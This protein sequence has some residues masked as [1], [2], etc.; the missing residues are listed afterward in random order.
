MKTAVI[1]GVRTFTALAAFLCLRAGHADVLVYE[2]F[3][4]ADYGN[5]AADGNVQAN[6]PFSAGHTI[7]FAATGWNGMNGTQV[8]VFGENYG[9]ALPQAM[10][11]AGFAATGGSVGL[12]P[13]SNSSEMR[14]MNHALASDALKTNSATLYFRMLLNLDSVAAGKLSASSAPSSAAGRYF[15]CGF[16]Q[17][18]GGNYYLLTNKKSALAFVVWKNADGQCVLSLA[19]T[20][21]SDAT[22]AFY[23]LVAGIALG[24]TYVC[25]AEVQVGAGADGKE[26]VRAGAVKADDFAGAAPWAAIGG[27]SDFVEVQ[28]MTDSSYPTV[29]AV[30]GPYGTNNGYFRAD[31]IVVGTEKGDVLPVSGVF[32]VAPSGAPTVGTD[33]FSTGWILVADQGVTADAAIVWSADE[34]FSTATTNSLGTGLSAGTRTASLSGLEPDTAYW[35]KIVADSGT[36]VAETPVLSFT[37]PGAPV[38]G[39]A[40]VALDGEAATFSVDLAEAAMVN[41]LATSVSVLY[42]TDGE[43]WTELRLGSASAAETFSGTATNLGFGVSYRWFARAA[44]TTEGGRVLSS[45][46]PEGSFTTL[47]NGDMYVDA[48]AT[49][50]APPYSTPETAAAT[51]AAA[52]A[53]ADDGA[54][55]HV[56]PGVYPISSPVAVSKAVRILGAGPD[57]SRTVVSNTVDASYYRQNQRVFRIDNAGALVANLTMQNGKCYSDGGDFYIAPAGG[58]VSN[59]VVEAGYTRDNGRAAGGWLDAGVVTHTVFRRNWSGSASVNWQGNRPGL[60]QLNGQ[61]RAE[62]CLFVG[63]DQFRAV[64]LIGMAGSSVMRNCTIVDTGLSVT[65]AYCESWSAL[66]IGQGAT[67]QNVVVA[68][69]TNTVDGAACRPTG[70]RENF[71]NGALD[72]PVEG[73]AFPANTVVGTAGVFFADGAGGDYVPKAGGPLV[74][75]GADGDEGA[76][77]DLAG[78]RRKVGRRVDIGCYECQKGGHFLVVVK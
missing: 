36:A 75:A 65:N 62:N 22:A 1:P 15:G 72:S 57:P 28:L 6:T 61:A 18:D 58:M 35:W 45:D 33:A 3:H 48:A 74:D 7:G 51:I 76:A 59:C 12:N 43:N 10:T 67:V 34:T 49:D 41:T 64:A 25:Y 13:G 53:A 56:A 60:L 29:L 73:T 14:A 31:E 44:A 37:T 4:P 66:R 46:S 38:L 71:L 52:L 19:H 21:A 9:L 8:R 55:V 70:S 17:S 27:S 16:T 47:W 77:V 24:S 2:G 5:V 32:A 39:A 20:T 63:N 68:G 26:V 30:A 69:V 42:G 54:T 78:K 50:A 40:A 23:P 11:D